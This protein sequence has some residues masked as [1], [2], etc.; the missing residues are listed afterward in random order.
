M[1]HTHKLEGDKACKMLLDDRAEARRSNIKE[2]RKG[3]EE[4]H[5]AKKE[6]TIKTPS[7]EEEPKKLSSPLSCLYVVPLAI[8]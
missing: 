7:K 2:A 5:W 3:C 6:E 4:Q 8:A 1:E